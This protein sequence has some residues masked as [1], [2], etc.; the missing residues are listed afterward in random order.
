MLSELPFYEEL[1]VIKTNH[2]FRGYAMSYKAEIIK[3]KYPIKE[4]EA[5]KLSIK[6]LFIDLLNETKG[7][8]YKIG[9][10]V[11]FKKYKPN[12]EIEFRPIY[13]NS[14]TKTVVNYKFSLKNAFQGIS[15]RID[16]WINEGSAWIVESIESIKSYRQLSGSSCMKLPA[17]LRSSKKRTNQHQT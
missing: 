7:S 2:A 13:F 14:T 9:L 5:S 11:M 8:K 17:E 3:K 15:Y 4:L 12:G 1:N 10:K 16:N 6:D